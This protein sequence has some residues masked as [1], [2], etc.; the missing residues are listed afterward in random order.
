MNGCENHPG[1]GFEGTEKGQQH[2]GWRSFGCPGRGCQGPHTRWGNIS[3]MGA[4]VFVL[5]I[6]ASPAPIKSARH[7]VGAPQIFLDCDA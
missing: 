2:D 5:F 4:G 7:I 6:S 1:L 3:S